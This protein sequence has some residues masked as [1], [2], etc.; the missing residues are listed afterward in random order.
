M[1]LWHGMLPDRRQT[2]ADEDHRPKDAV[3]VSWTIAEAVR[4]FK[5]FFD[6]LR[7]NAVRIAAYA[8][9]AR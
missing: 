9:N 4:T 6:V 7:N 2:L 5:K 3:A 1:L 8:V